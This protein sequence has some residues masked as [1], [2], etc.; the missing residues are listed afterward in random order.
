MD[1]P[2]VPS[3]CMGLDGSMTVV[4]YIYV[5]LVHDIRTSAFHVKETDLSLTHTPER[6]ATHCN[7]RCMA[8]S[9]TCGN[10]MDASKSSTYIA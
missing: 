8:R 9:W 4:L 7:L 3:I 6:R 1:V 2:S 5:V 10:G